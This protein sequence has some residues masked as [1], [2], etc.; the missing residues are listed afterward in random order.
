M[1]RPAL[2]LRLA[3]A[4]VALQKPLSSPHSGHV[5]Y[6]PFFPVHAFKSLHPHQLLDRPLVFV[7]PELQSTQLLLLLAQR[8]IELPNLL[9]HAITLHVQFVNLPPDN[10]LTTQQGQQLPMVQNALFGAMAGQ[11]ASQRGFLLG[12]PRQRL[13]QWQKLLLGAQNGLL[14]AALAGIAERQQSAPVRQ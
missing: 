4:T 3:P 11:Q 12:E 7:M 9:F 8:F 14:A 6:F 10:R 1:A 13:T 5:F 2:A